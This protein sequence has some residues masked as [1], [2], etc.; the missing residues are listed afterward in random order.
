MFL[1]RILA[2]QDAAVAQKKTEYPYQQLLRDLDAKQPVLRPFEASLRGKVLRLIAEVKKASPSKGLL[3]PDFDPERLARAYELAGAAAISVL[4]EEVHFGGSLTDLGRVKTC[5]T[6]TPVLRK[7]FIVDPYQLLEA[8][9]YG[10]DAVLLIVAALNGSQLGQLCRETKELGMTPLV[11]VHNQE[12]VQ[13]ALDAG[14]TVV[15]INNR[16]LYTFEVRLATTYQLLTKLPAT[17]LKVSESGITTREDLARLEAG[18]VNAVLVGEALVT[19]V[20]PSA[21]IRELL[22]EDP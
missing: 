18:G 8:R 14:A 9:L 13:K 21:K 20:D 5:T 11:E 16:N 22:G 12:E 15:G 4:T 6:H 7:D 3:C 17:V 19:A 10:A 1:E 2:K